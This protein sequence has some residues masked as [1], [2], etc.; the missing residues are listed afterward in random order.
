[1]AVHIPPTPDMVDFE[2]NITP[3]IESKI[4]TN[5]HLR[6]N[7]PV[8]TIKN[9][10]FNHF[11]KKYKNPDGTPMFKTYDNFHPEVTTTALRSE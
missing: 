2:T 5:L 4:G 11:N 1:M 9:I 8:C 10:I 3:T 7:H 6:V